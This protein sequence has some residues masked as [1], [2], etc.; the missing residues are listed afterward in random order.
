MAGGAAYLARLPFP[1]PFFP[2]S[3]FLLS[4]SLSSLSLSLALSS[5]VLSPPVWIFGRFW[6]AS[7]TADVARLR[8]GFEVVDGGP[9]CRMAPLRVAAAPDRVL[10]IVSV[11]DLAGWWSFGVDVVVGVNV[12]VCA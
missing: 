2:F 6:V 12:V 3:F 7:S 9:W 11:V 4:R 5:S 8:P 10:R 1:F